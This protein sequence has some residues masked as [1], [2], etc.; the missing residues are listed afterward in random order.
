MKYNLVKV[1]AIFFI[2]TIVAC[3]NKD[4]D[5]QPGNSGDEKKVKIVLTK[6][7]AFTNYKETLFIQLITDNFNEVNVSGVADSWNTHE[8]GPLNESVAEGGA[9]FEKS[10]DQSPQSLTLATTTEVK[11]FT[12]TEFFQEDGDIENT[13]F[14]V[15]A[16]IYLNDKKIDSKQFTANVSAPVHIEFDVSD[17]D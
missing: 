4:D 10:Y 15:N 11:Y 12:L 5:P 16:D 1:L 6:D 14:N 9:S 17:Y 8:K 2:T 13:D 7:G 3:S